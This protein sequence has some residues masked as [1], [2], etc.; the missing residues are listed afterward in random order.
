MDRFT[1]LI[2]TLQS[3]YG[4]LSCFAWCRDGVWGTDV[5]PGSSPYNK[6]FDTYLNMFYG[7]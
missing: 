4:S 7:H 5:V 3:M 2:Q 6:I 1:A